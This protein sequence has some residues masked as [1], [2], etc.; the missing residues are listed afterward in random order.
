MLAAGA[1]AI[2]LWSSTLA[3]AADLYW[4]APSGDWSSAANWGGSVPWNGDSA[5]ITNGGTATITQ[6][7]VCDSFYLG[8][9]GTGTIRLT[10]GS[11]W[12]NDS[13]YVGYLGTGSFTQTGGS[14]T[15]NQVYV[16]YGT[17]VSGTYSLTGI[18]QL[19]PRNEEYVGYR[20]TGSF[21]QSGGTTPPPL[22]ISVTTPAP[23]G[24]TASAAPVNWGGDR[25]DEYVG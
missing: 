22:S 20:G 4:S 17:G 6:A 16:G 19:S 8:N 9:V 18:G 7:E 25:D 13:A 10:A 23:T 21:T 3:Q 14:S 2:L 11:L 12:A 15:P 1:M 5:W 24:R